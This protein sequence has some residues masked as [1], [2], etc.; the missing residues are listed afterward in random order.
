[1]EYRSPMAIPGHVAKDFLSP[2]RPASV[3]P[4]GV[5]LSVCELEELSGGG[6]LGEGRRE[7][8]PGRPLEASEGFWRLRPGVY[9]IRYCEAV[10]VPEHALGLVFPRSSLIRMGAVVH[11]AVWDPGYRGRGEGLLVVHNELLLER[12]A[13]V[14]QIVFL[15]LTESPKSLY[16]GVYQG[17]GL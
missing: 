15:K 8:P 1:M 16:S 11:G 5:D 7:R 9:R 3:Q 12:G 2:S 4:A 13:R 6:A 14:A 17:E 10:A